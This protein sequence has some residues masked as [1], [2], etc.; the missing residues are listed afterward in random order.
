MP[1]HLHAQGWQSMCPQNYYS[2]VIMGSIASQ[3][4]SLTIVCSSVNSGA[5][6]KKHQSSA[7]LA[8]VR[9]NHRRPVNS[10][11]KGSVTRKLFPFDDVI[12]HCIWRIMKNFSILHLRFH[13]LYW[14]KSYG[15]SMD[16]LRE[17]FG[18]KWPR[19][20]GSAPHNDWWSLQCQMP[21]RR[22]CRVV[23]KLRACRWQLN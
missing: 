18:E 13:L 5:D 21:R 9:G 17:L 15:R 7:S 1:G 22:R 4:T 20:M 10:P 16:V 19:D 3:I 11:H 12:I 14:S 6:Q 2:D 23:T 8:F